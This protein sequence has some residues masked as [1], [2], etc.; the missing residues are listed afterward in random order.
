MNIK[1]TEALY[2]AMEAV[3]REPAK[4]T[5]HMRERIAA[6]IYGSSPSF[7][8]RPREYI[9]R[10]FLWKTEQSRAM[11]EEWADGFLLCCDELG[12]EVLDIKN[13]DHAPGA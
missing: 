5:G 4:S 13:D 3:K 7:Y 6:A 8:E 9:Y 2:K 12:L 10:M 11:Y 1:A